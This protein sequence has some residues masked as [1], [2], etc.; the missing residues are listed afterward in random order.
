MLPG[1][2]FPGMTPGRWGLAGLAVLVA[3]ALPL[4]LSNQYLLGVMITTLILLVLNISWNFVLGVAGVWNFGQLAV[5][6]LGGYGAGIIMLHSSVSPWL[7]L[8]AGGLVGMV[9]AVLLSFPTLRLYG[10]YTSLLTFAFAEVIQYVILNDGSGLT[11]G[12]FGLPIVRGLYSSLSLNASAGA[13]F[14]TALAVVVIATVLLAAVSHARFGIALRA[15]RDAPAYAAAR[16]VSPLRYR[17]AAFAVSGFL[18]GIAGGLYVSYD[19]SISPSVMG[20]TPMSV[21]VTMLVIGGLGTTTGPII[22]TI[23]VQVVATAL[24]THPGAEFTI[25]GLFLLAVVI[26]VPEG[27]TGLI[28]RYWRKVAAWAAEDGSGEDENAEGTTTENKTTAGLTKGSPDPH[29]A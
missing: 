4:V 10:I 5:Y 29:V 16:G 9:A 8:L 19:Q 25:L 21:Y 18:A 26:F 7:A 24:V 27:L 20:L 13:Y 6:A 15:I 14:W 3:A 11:G 2:V 12:S 22:G 23:C 17:I 1:A 28:A